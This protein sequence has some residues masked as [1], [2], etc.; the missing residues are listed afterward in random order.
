M[1]GLVVNF[2][3]NMEDRFNVS[4]RD[5]NNR[6]TWG[7]QKLTPKDIGNNPGES[8]REDGINYYFEVHSSRMNSFIDWLDDVEQVMGIPIKFRYCNTE[9]EAWT[10]YGGNLYCHRW[11][12][13]KK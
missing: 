7:I 11:L 5:F 6:Q 8:A 9:K 12:T 13:I 2:P 1:G 4:I 3:F 10:G